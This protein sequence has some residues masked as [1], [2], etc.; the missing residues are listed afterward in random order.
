MQYKKH[1]TL[2]VFIGKNI[3]LEDYMSEQAFIS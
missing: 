1:G 2:H 3:T